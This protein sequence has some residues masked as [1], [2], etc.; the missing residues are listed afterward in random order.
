MASF[1]PHPYSSREDVRKC[2]Q[3]FR[4][5]C[6]GALLCRST[7]K[8][9]FLRVERAW[10]RSF[11]DSYLRY[12]GT[13]SAGGRVSEEFK[14]RREKEDSNSTTP[15]PG[16]LPWN[17]TG[18]GYDNG[19]KQSSVHGPLVKNPPPLRES[20]IHSRNNRSV[21]SWTI[22]INHPFFLPDKKIFPR[23]FYGATSPVKS[24]CE[25]FIHTFDEEES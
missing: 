4:R 7:R 15:P 20:Q 24:L 6:T 11:E 21:C 2:C 3:H 1:S 18:T 10:D 12:G 22:P 17:C 23:R 13:I 16:F 19:G 8:S 9:R 5:Y 25:A 14:K